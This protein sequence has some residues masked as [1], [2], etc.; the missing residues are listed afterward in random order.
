MFGKKYERLCH[1]YTDK[2]KE[3][4]IFMAFA[5]LC[6]Y[7]Y[8]LI[9]LC[10]WALFLCSASSE[11]VIMDLAIIFPVLMTRMIYTGGLD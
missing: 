6:L 3:K 2:L 4:H 8:Q 9:V 11:I 1:L 5:G 7:V 10:S